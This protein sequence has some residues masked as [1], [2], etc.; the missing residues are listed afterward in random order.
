LYTAPEQPKTGEKKPE[1]MT[2][3]ELNQLYTKLGSDYQIN[4]SGDLGI[5]LQS[6]SDLIQK[7]Q[8]EQT[9]ST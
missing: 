9:V 4:P 1:E 8:Q 6:V 2:L 7:R 3:D 5:K